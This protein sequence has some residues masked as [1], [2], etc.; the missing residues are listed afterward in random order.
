MAVALHT[1]LLTLPRSALEE[2]FRAAIAAVEANQRGDRRGWQ[3]IDGHEVLTLEDGVRF[4]PD[5]QDA[6]AGLA[7]M[8]IGGIAAVFGVAFVGIVIDGAQAEPWMRFAGVGLLAAGG[9]L[10]WTG[11]D[12]N[13][14]ARAAPRLTGAYLFD[15]A[16]VHVSTMG[17]QRFPLERV[18]GFGYRAT[19]DGTRSKLFIDYVDDEGIERDEVL[20][21]HDATATLAEWRTRS[22]EL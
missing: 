13:R 22:G 11:R 3:T 6:K 8:I 7:G 1:D 15:D 12:E 5:G 20:L 21:Y 19:S 2:R 18:R 10:V 14:V 4:V 16:L 9:Y 17:C